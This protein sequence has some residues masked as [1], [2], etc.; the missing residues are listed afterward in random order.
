MEDLKKWKKALIYD[1]GLILVINVLILVDRMIGFTFGLDDPRTAILSVILL[2]VGIILT[3]RVPIAG[4][5]IG[6]ITG[7]LMILSLQ[8]INILLGVLITAHAILF[9]NKYSIQKNK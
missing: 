7:I 4:G 9:L 3:N 5:I 2:I 1:Y 6:I 8:L